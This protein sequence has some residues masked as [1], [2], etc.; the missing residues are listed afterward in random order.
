M[1]LLNVKTYTLEQYIDCSRA[2]QYA[3]LSHTWGEDEV[4]FGDII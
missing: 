2:P 3:I 4:L 1:R